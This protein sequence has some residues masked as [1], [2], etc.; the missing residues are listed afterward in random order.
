MRR[1]W[2]AAC[3]A[4]WT[5]RNSAHVW[6]RSLACVFW[7]ST[8]THKSRTAMRRCSPASWAPDLRFGGVPALFHTH[9]GGSFEEEQHQLAHRPHGV[10]HPHD[11]PLYS[12]LP[13]PPMGQIH[14]IVGAREANLSKHAPQ[15]DVG[16][17]VE[18]DPV[19]HD[20][21]TLPPDAQP[22]AQA[23]GQPAIEREAI[24]SGG[25]AELVSGLKKENAAGFQRAMQSPQAEAPVFDVF[26]HG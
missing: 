18:V 3:Y 2:R 25:E 12:A 16:E 6:A 22:I 14:A 7:N 26:E 11:C 13:S 23:V 17:L 24:L 5:I 4:C 10:A 20:V 19:L 15:A 1:R 9:E 21:G 8:R